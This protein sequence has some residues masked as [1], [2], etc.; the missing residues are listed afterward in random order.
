MALN[1][2]PTQTADLLADAARAL[3]G[4]AEWKAP[5]SRELGVNMRTIQAWLSGKMQLAP[6]HDVMRRTLGLLSALKP[7]IERV[8]PHVD[9][10]PEVLRRMHDA[11][12]TQLSE[13]NRVMPL[14]A[15][16]LATRAPAARRHK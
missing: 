9:R 15:A 11:L 3:Y 7:A 12:S 6:D 4:E 13:I 1:R 14:I 8:L 10:G 5:L 2:P 16:G